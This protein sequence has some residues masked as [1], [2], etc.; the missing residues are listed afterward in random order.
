VIIKRIF[1]GISHALA[2]HGGGLTQS[3]STCVTLPLADFLPVRHG[4]RV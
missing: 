1:P 4:E 2:R 3:F